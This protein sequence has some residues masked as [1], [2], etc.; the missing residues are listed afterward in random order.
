LRPVRD[1][2]ISDSTRDDLSTGQIKTNAMKTRGDDQ[3]VIQT[4]RKNIYDATIH[5][6][7]LLCLSAL[8]AL[9]QSSAGGGSIQGTVHDAAGAQVPGARVQIRNLATGVVTNT[10]TN[11]EGYFTTPSLTI[12]RYRVR[13]EA[14]GMKAWQGELQVETAR[15][16]E[17]APMLTVGEVSETVIIEG[18]ISPIITTTDP[19]DGST[20]DAM[21]IQELPLNGRSLNT[22]LEDVTPGVEDTGG[23]NGGVR[24]AGLMTYSTDYV[25][26]GVNTN[27]R[28]FGGSMGLQGLDSIAEVRVETTTS[29]AKYTRP[30]SV[31]VTTKG[32]SNQIHGSL[33]EIH[34]NNAFGVARARQ[35]VLPGGDYKVPKLIRNEYGGSIS[36]P[37]VLPSFGLNGQ[38]WYNG[39]NRTFFFFSREGLSFRTGATRGFR[40]PTQAMREG[41]FSGLVDAQGRQITIYD[42]L[43]TRIERINNRDIAVRDPFPG[44]RIPLNRMSPLAKFVFGITPL[45]NDITN[46]LIA[47]NLRMPFATSGLPNVNDNPTTIR[48]DH[49]FGEKDNTFFKV[50]GGKRPA[51][52]IG[53]ASN[54]GVPT[55]NNEANVT[56]LPMEN[57]QGAFSWNHVFS[58][59][60]FVET[61][62][63]RVWQSTETITGPPNN[64]RDWSQ[65]LGLPNPLGEIGFPNITG[66]GLTN[67]NLIEGDNRRALWSI[68]TNV[69][70]NYTLVKGTHNIQF[71]GR[72][73]HERQ[74]LIPDQGAISGS[75]AFSSLATALHSST[76]GNAQSPSAVPQTGFDLANLFLGYAST[77]QVG[78]KRRIM[79]VSEKNFG[80]YLQDNWKVSN[81]LTLTPGF[82][83][84]IN[85]AFTERNGLLN[86]FDLKGHALA[87]PYPL[88]HYYRLGVTSP[89]IVAQ[90][91]SVGV[92]FTTT[93]AAGLKQSIFPSNYFDIGPRAGFA[94]RMW[95]GNRQMVV[96]GGYGLYISA[97]PMRTWLAQ[98]SGLAP[99]RANF[100]Y[101]PNNAAFSPDGVSNYLLRTK[102][103][104]VAGVNST[105][106]VDINSSAGLGVGTAVR[107]LDTRQPSLR[108]HEWNLA[109]EKQIAK[110]TVIRFRYTGKHG[111]NSDQLFEINP[112]PNNYIWYTTTGLP[113]PTGR[114]AN[115]ARRPYDKEAYTDVRLLQKSG[116]INTSILSAEVERRFSKGLSFQAFYTLTN[117]LRLAGNSFRD[118][119]A[120]APE[121]FLPG[122]VPTDFDELNRFLFYDRE[123]GVPKHRVR[124]NWNYELPFGKGKSFARTAGGFLNAVIG[125][126]K[127]SGTGTVMSTWFAQ[128]TVNWGEFGNFEVYGR[129]HKI[130]DCRGTPVTANSPAQERCT[131]GYL[132]FNGY[133][134]ERV[135][136]LKNANGLR[137]GVFGL[138]DNYKPAVKPIIPWPKG[139]Q[140]TDP[141]ANLYDTNTV[142]IRL[143][144]GQVVNGVT[145]DTGLHPWRNQYRLGPFNWVMD[146]SM[147]KF[148][149]FNE[150]VQLRV[151]VDVFNV[152]NV[153]GL[154]TPN[155]EGIVSL[156][157]SF[158][159][160]GQIAFRPRQLQAGLRLQW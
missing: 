68:V 95:D 153:Q 34:R 79:Q 85:P 24:I 152:F 90:F 136:N 8:P 39:K 81:R 101:N 40:V 50:A 93:E 70:Q 74:H 72:F 115:V 36:G 44:N 9:G 69:D 111:V 11:S 99:F 17:I 20:L 42:P 159:P 58:S 51:Y 86:T 96:R 145:Y 106:T 62:V 116:Y 98:F 45:P 76:L 84:D 55:L 89:G 21:R 71:G 65:E 122:A 23:V 7:L 35:D 88:E 160:N 10:V 91:Q 43:T 107:A 25:A 41:D 108:I 27:N 32:G 13:V 6:F 141:G 48:I 127:W 103:T 109:I 63:N 3:E 125:G 18:A 157:S 133:I 87:F 60:F 29:S 78:L 14:R 143:N 105:N 82:R 130:L 61:L 19:T 158:N 117:A 4:M 2:T 134:S 146:T 124:W 150:K 92:K 49:R 56:Y 1:P 73:H 132:W 52:F 144:S 154:N 156:G 97:V 33:F 12:G 22:L 112:Q 83:W 66:T 46:P 77:Y 138:P 129:K 149:R 142:S 139:G 30:T 126:W 120:S 123:T 26:D 140:T 57:I 75:V 118:D 31:I 59:N 53:T 128:P 137:I 119:V 155:A 80:L 102:P 104:I 148:F 16:A 15:S 28:E 151:N 5:V 64:Q 47:D 121:A 113:L 67:Y 131:P 114:F 94:Y 147:M 38:R 100:N 54:N 37:I 110:S 135:I